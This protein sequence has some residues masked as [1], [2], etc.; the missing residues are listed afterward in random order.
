[1][2]DHHSLTA[3]LSARSDMLAEAARNKY[4]PKKS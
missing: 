2:K 3:T 4:L 1:V